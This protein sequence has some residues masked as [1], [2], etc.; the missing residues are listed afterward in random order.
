MADILP[1]SQ[2]HSK[3]FGYIDYFLKHKRG[4]GLFEIIKK[5]ALIGPMSKYNLSAL[6][7]NTNSTNFSWILVHKYLKTLKTN[8]L[9]KEFGKHQGPKHESILY[10][11][12]FMGIIVSCL[13]DDEI[14]EKRSQIIQNYSKYD[15]KHSSQFFVEE[16]IGEITAPKSLEINNQPTPLWKGVG[17]LIRILEFTKSVV[18]ILPET[19]NVFAPEN[20][21][22]ILVK[23]INIDTKL[24]VQFFDTLSNEIIEIGPGKN[25]QHKFDKI[26]ESLIEKCLLNDLI[27]WLGNLKAKINLRSYL[28]NKSL[29]KLESWYASQRNL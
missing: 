20:L 25:N 26:V 13:V 23:K 29:D 19:T 11:L 27:G 17:K 18:N 22:T 14:F 16:K 9:V 12:T 28:L 10:G 7:K 1:L 3:G 24:Y 6:S 8:A 2:K 5:L 15:N 4:R 21:T